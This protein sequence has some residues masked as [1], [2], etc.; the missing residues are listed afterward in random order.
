MENNKRAKVALNRS[1]ELKGVIV[2]T[3]CVAEIL[4]ES[5][6]ALT[7]K[8]IQAPLAMP[9][10]P[11]HLNKLDNGQPGN[12]IYQISRKVKEPP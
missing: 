11:L 1:P 8:Q 9:N 12:A 5:A 6:W 3:V 7:N 10:G 2:Q 4:S